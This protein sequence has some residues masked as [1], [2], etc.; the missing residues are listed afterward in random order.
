MNETQ[1]RLGTRRLAPG[2]VRRLARLGGL[3]Y[4]V[5][6]AGALLFALQARDEV[7]NLGAV[8]LIALFCA[9]AASR[10]WPRRAR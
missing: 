8:V 1:G 4:A 2:A 7:Q 5:A 3:L 9:V 6:G 10:S